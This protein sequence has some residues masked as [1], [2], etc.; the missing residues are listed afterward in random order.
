M[1]A[2]FRCLFTTL[3]F[4]LNAHRLMAEV[5][6]PVFAP[7]GEVS[8]T[9]TSISISCSTP[10]ATIHYTTNGVDPAESDALIQSGSA[11]YVGRNLVLKARAWKDG[12]S[13]A[14]ASQSYSITGQVSAGDY[15][16]LALK[17]DGAKVS[18]WGRNLEGQL[19]TGTTTQQN[20]PIYAIINPSLLPISSIAAKG[21]HSLAITG[22]HN[23]ISWG[24][25]LSGELG[26]GTT[27]NQALAVTVQTGTG[28]G[29]ANLAGIAEVCGGVYSSYALK[30]SG[31]IGTIWSWGS[32]SS[33]KLGDGTTTTRT[34][35]VQVKTGSNS[36]VTNAVALS[37]G[38]NFALALTS[39]NKVLVWG[40]NDN[41][42][43]GDGGSA[44]RYY[45][46][47]IP[48]FEGVVAVAA[49]YSHSLALK[50]NG[51]L[52][53]WGS[54]S[55]GQV[56]D[57]SPTTRRSP[58]QVMM[59][60]T[61]P[62]ENVVEVAAGYLHSLALKADGTVWAWGY[63]SY[64]LLGDGSH[65][66]G[67][68][69]YYPVQVKTGSNS[70]LTNVVAISAGYQLSV[71]L[72]ADGTIYTW[73]AGNYGQL[74]ND[75]V[76]ANSY[77]TPSF[78]SKVINTPPS[79]S[80][81]L[82]AGPYMQGATLT[83]SAV[84]SDT[85]NNLSRVDL[86]QNGSSLGS[87]TSGSNTLTLS[88]V[89]AGQY[90]FTAVATDI[91]GDFGSASVTASVTLPPTTVGISSFDS[92][93]TETSGTSALVTVTRQGGTSGPLSI[94][95]SVAG[96]A[97]S[98]SDYQ[99]LSGTVIIPVGA[100]S[101]CIPITP[102]VDRL[103]E[104]DET[105]TITLNSAFGYSVDANASVATVTIH[106]APPVA[107]PLFATRPGYSLEARPVVVTCA[108]E[109][110]VIH[111]TINGEVPT[112][113][114]TTS[115]I[116][117]QS[118]PNVPPNAIIRLTAC[119]AGYP[120]SDCAAAVYQFGPT[121]KSG[122]YHSLAVDP[123]GKL[124][125]WGDNHA[126]QIG[127][128]SYT[129]QSYPALIP[130]IPKLG[131][132]AAGDSH[133]LCI[134]LDGCVWSWGAGNN[135]QLGNGG[136]ASKL[137]PTKIDAFGP[138][139]YSR[140]V[141]VA[142]GYIF[143][144]ALDSNR[145]VWTWGHNNYGQIGDDTNTQR[146]SPVQV[147]GIDHI[148][149]IAAGYGHAL[150]LRDDG[151][152]WGWGANGSGQL[153]DGT[154]IDRKTPVQVV[155]LNDVVALDAGDDHTVALKADGTVWTW[156]DN[157]YGVL[158]TSLNNIYTPL[159]VQGIDP[160]M[161]VAAGHHHIIALARDG[162]IYTW[163]CNDSGQLGDGTQVSRN[164]RTRVSNLS[165]IV[166]IDAGNYTT[167]AIDRWG[168]IWA[169]GY[170]DGGVLG[171]D[172]S[173][174]V[175]TP[176]RLEELALKTRT[177]SP[178]ISP[179]GGRSLGAQTITIS[180]DTP[181]AV[182]RT[183]TNGAVPTESD[184]I[185]VSGSSITISAPA[186][187]RAKAFLDGIA[188]SATTTVC[189]G[190]G[191][192]VAADGAAHN[193]AL[194]T[195]GTVW[196]WGDNTDGGLGIG[197]ETGVEAVP[198]KLDWS[199]TASVIASSQG[200]AFS[201][202]IDTQGSVWLWGANDRGQLGTGGTDVSISPAQQAGL[203]QVAQIALGISHSLA[204]KQDGTVW[205]WGDNTVGELGTGTMS[206]VPQTSPVQVT[207]TNSVPLS[208][209]V[210]ITSGSNFSVALKGDGTV[211]AWGYDGKGQ[212]GDSYR[213]YTKPNSSRP[214]RVGSAMIGGPLHNVIAIA[215]GVDHTL[216]LKADGTV[217]G[218]GGDVHGQLGDNRV[219]QNRSEPTQA[220]N[221]TNV[222]A[223]YAGNAVSF[224]VKADGTVWAWGDNTKGQYGNGTLVESFVPIQIATLTSPSSIAIGSDHALAAGIAQ[225]V[226]VFSAW[227]TNTGGSLGNGNSDVTAVQSQPQY[228]HLG[229]DSD[230]DG[231]PDWQ[232]IQIGTN[233][234]NWDTDG[235]G[236]P[237]GWEVDNGFNP[238]DP[239]DAQQ[240][241]DGDGLTNLQEYQN[242][243]NPFLVDTD[244]DGIPD[245]WEV[246][247]GLNP[248]DAADA[249]QDYDGDGLTN[250]QEYQN[251][252]N[253]F[254]VDTDGDGI[255]DEWEVRY[256]L[257]PLDPTDAAQDYDGDGYSNY[258]EYIA[259]T[260]PN[261]SESNAGPVLIVDQSNS[262][263]YVTVQSAI[264]A[265]T[266][267]YQ[268]INVSPGTYS[269]NLTISN[270]KLFLAS[271]NGAAVTVIS[272]TADGSSINVANDSQIS[273][274][275]I[276]S[277]STNTS[278]ERGVLVQSGSP[279][280]T[281]CVIR[282]N[283]ASSGAA[284]YSTGANPSF[285]NCTMIGN[286][287]ESG[288]VAT[289]SGTLTIV[290]SILW[291][292]SANTELTGTTLRVSYSDVRGGIAGDGNLDSN[293]AVSQDGHLI[294]PLSVCIGAGQ[295]ASAPQVDMDCEVRDSA[296]DIGADEFVDTDGNQLPDWWERQY[297]GNIGNDAN[298]PAT[299][300]D[301]LSIFQALLQNRNPIDYY[302]GQVV[303]LVEVG[304]GGQLGRAGQ[305]GTTPWTVQLTDAS[306]VP[307]S[308]APVRFHVSAGDGQISLGNDG[309]ASG[310][311]SI[312][313]LTDSSGFA[314]IYPVYPSAQDTDST[315]DATASTSLVQSR[316][317]STSLIASWNL[318]E[319]G[320]VTAEDQ[321][322]LGNVGGIVGSPSWV[323]G[324]D[325]FAALALDGSSQ[326]VQI[327]DKPSLSLGGGPLTVTAWVRLDQNASLASESDCYSV[328]C[329]GSTGVGNIEFS[330]RGG[331]FNGLCAKLSDGSDSFD[332]KAST[333]QSGKLKDNCW[334]HV[335]FV[336]HGSGDGSIFLDGLLVGSGT[337]SNCNIDS[338]QP[339]WIGRNGAG[340]HLMGS[341]ARVSVYARDLS[342]GEVAQ[343]RNADYD[344]DG[345]PDWWE[346]LQGLNPQDPTD[347]ALDPDG[348]GLSNIEEFQLGTN[349][350]IDSNSG[351][352]TSITK[353]SGDNQNG[354]PNSLLARPMV[355][356]VSD[357]NGNPLVNAPVIFSVEQ[358]GGQLTSGTFSPLHADRIPLLTDTTGRVAI[359]YREGTVFGTNSTVNATVA[360]N[361][362]QFTASSSPLVGL[363]K[364][365]ER[366]G[367]TV[368][369]LSNTEPQV[370]LTG[371]VTWTTGFDGKGAISL[372]GTSG[373]VA[374]TSNAAL[375]T[376][377]GAY[378]IATW[379]RLPSDLDLGDE[380]LR[381]PL[382][383]VGD[384]DAD[385]LWIGIRGGGHGLAAILNAPAGNTEIDG[386]VDQSSLCDGGW[387]HIALVFDGAN[388][389]IFFDGETI[390]SQDCDGLPLTA[391]PH[392]W[393]AK[394]AAGLF[395]GGSID[396]TEVRRDSLSGDDIRARYNVD[397]N[398]DGIPDRW[399]W[400]YFGTLD[401]DP[402]ADL[403]GDGISNFD[404]FQNGTDPTDPA[405]LSSLGDFTNINAVRS[406][407]LMAA[408]MTMSAS[409][410]S[411][412]TPSIPTTPGSM[413]GSFAVSPSG[414]ATYSVPISVPKGASGMEPKLFLNYSSQS[415]NGS[416][417]LGW[418][419]GGLSVI[420]RGP[421]NLA[422][423]GRID[424]VNFDADDQ[425]FLD[426]E[427]LIPIH[428]KGGADGT[429]YRTQND[430]FYK[431]ISHG[432]Y[433][434]R[435]PVWWEVKTKSGLT[436]RIGD[437]DCARIDNIAYSAVISWAVDEIIDRNNNYL[438]VWYD[439]EFKASVK[440]AANYEPRF[441]WYTGN[442]EVKPTNQVEF[443][444]DTARPD[445]SYGFVVGNPVKTEKRLTSIR[446]Y[447]RGNLNGVS[448]DFNNADT[449]TSKYAGT[450][451]REYRL[452]YESTSGYDSTRQ[453]QR[454]H[455]QSIQ[456]IA[457]DEQGY[458]A[459]AFPPTVFTWKKPQ[460][461]GWLAAPNWKVN[462][463][464]AK[465][466]CPDRGVVFIDVNGDGLVDVIWNRKKSDGTFDKGAYINTGTGWA[467]DSRF[468]PPI[469]LA[470]DD[471]S[472]TGARI[473]D[474][475]GDG[476][477]DIVGPTKCYI[478]VPNSGWVRS[479][480][481]ALPPEAALVD[482]D[483]GMRVVDLNGDGRA[484]LLYGHKT[485]SGDVKKAWIATGTGWNPAPEW[486][487]PA[488]FSNK[489]NEV[490]RH[491]S[492]LDVNGDGLPD[493]IYRDGDQVGCFM[494]K[495]AGNGTVPSS[496]W[497]SDE[498]YKPLTQITDDGR[499]RG[500]RLVDMNGDGLPDF[501][502]RF[503]GSDSDDPDQMGGWF[504][505]GV[506]IKTADGGAWRYDSSLIPP[507]V[508]AKRANGTFRDGE[509]GCRFVDLNGDGLM[510]LVRRHDV[511][512]IYLGYIDQK[513]NFSWK[514]SSAWN[515]PYSTLIDDQVDAG[516]RF[517]DLNGDG[518]PDF[519]YNR[520][521]RD[522]TTDSGAYINKSTPEVIEK[523]TNGLGSWVSF[524]YKPLSDG[525]VYAKG[526]SPK[527]PS[528]NVTPTTQVV[529][530]CSIDNGQGGA[531]ATTYNYS[532]LQQ[533]QLGRGSLGFGQ[534]SQTTVMGNDWT[535]IIDSYCHDFPF[536]GLLRS[537]KKYAGL[538]LVAS[539][540]NTWV[541][542]A[543]PYFESGAKI[544]NLCFV[545]NK[546]SIIKEF[547]AEIVGSNMISS[548]TT[549]NAYDQYG[550]LTDSTIDSGAG[551]KKVLHN[552]YAAPSVADLASWTL[553]RLKDA[554]SQS[555]APGVNATTAPRKASSFT[556]KAN[557][558]LDG[559][560][561]EPGNAN[562][563]STTY[564]ADR[565]GNIIRTD[566]VGAANLSDDLVTLVTGTRSSFSQYD[567]TGRF[568]LSATNA[569]GQASFTDPDYL[570][571]L[572][573]SVTDINGLTTSF[574]YDRFGRPISK[575]D[576][577]GVVAS[578]EFS[579]DSGSD[580]YWPVGAVYSVKQ[581]TT[582]P[583]TGIATAA[584]GTIA[585]VSVSYYDRLN[586]VLRIRSEIF[587]KTQPGVVL[588]DTKYDAYGRTSMTSLPYV[589]GSTQLWIKY[590]YDAL[591][592]VVRVTN[593]DDSYAFWGYASIRGGGSRVIA[594]DPLG[595]S[596]TTETNR[597]GQ[598]TK[599][600]DCQNGVI[601]YAYDAYGNPKST[602]SPGNVVTSFTYDAF[603][604]KLAMT[605]ADMGKW[606]Y[607]YNGFGE[608]IQQ[609]NVAAL[610]KGQPRGQITPALSTYFWYDLSGRT[611][612]K[613]AQ[614]TNWGF[615]T[616]TYVYDNSTNGPA[617]TRGK[618]LSV[619]KS[620]S[621][622]RE[623]YGY[624]DK[625]R[626]TSIA[627]T[628]NTLASGTYTIGKTYDEIGREKTTTYPNGFAT[629]NQYD[630]KGWLCSVVNA[631]TPSLAY[632]T[633]DSM[634]AGGRVTGESFGNGANTRHDYDPKTG[635]TTDIVTTSGTGAIQYNHYAFNSL[636]NLMSRQDR[637]QG[638]QLETFGYDSLNR[639]ISAVS[640]T[641]STGV[642]YDASGGILSKDGVGTYVYNTASH[643][644][645]SIKSGTTVLSSYTY[646][647]RGNMLTGAGRTYTWNSEDK[648]VTI[649]DT[650]GV[651]ASFTYG[652]GGEI[653]TE[654]L[655]GPNT[656][657][658][659]THIGGIYEVVADR[660]DGIGV[661]V[662]KFQRCYIGG[663]AVVIKK[664]ADNSTTTRYFHKDHLG[665]VEAVTDE[666]G[667]VVERF[668]YDAWGART[669]T[670][671]TPDAAS[672]PTTEQGFTGHQELDDLGLI[673]MIGRVYDPVI[674]RFVSAD[675][676]VQAPGNSQ[677]YNRYSYCINNPL[678]LTDPTGYSWLSS[679]WNA[680][681]HA[682][683]K[684]GAWVGG[685]CTSAGKWIS[686]NWRTIVVVVATVV[687]TVATAGTLTTALGPLWGVVASGALAGAVNG[688]L[689]TA[690][691]GGSASQI[692]HNALRGAI[693]GGVTAGLTYGIG[694]AA[695]SLFGVEEAEGLEGCLAK[696]P[697]EGAVGGGLSAA[698]GG[699]FKSGFIGG[700]VGC[701]SGGVLDGSTNVALNTVIA[702]AAGGTVSVLCGGSFAN[703]AV[704]AAFAYVFNAVAHRA[705]AMWEYPESRVTAYGF[706]KDNAYADHPDGGDA[707]SYASDPSRND[708]DIAHAVLGDG[709]F[710]YPS[711][712]AV[713]P[714]SGIR[715]GSRV[716]VESRGWFVVED[717][718][719]EDMDIN[720]FDM[721]TGR[722]DIALRSS[723]SGR[724]NV[725]V[726]PKGL[727]VPD[728]WRARGAGDSWGFAP[729]GNTRSAYAN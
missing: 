281:N 112:E 455:L 470:A 602:K 385:N 273:G 666:L 176:A 661:A 590:E 187:V 183:S 366:T 305:T 261:D 111:Y 441:I 229:T 35:A 266:Q 675:P 647:A 209:I 582:A 351:V 539:T 117:G 158:G 571:G 224:A 250:L 5:A 375:A 484:D 649:S 490:S 123:D 73:G 427:R 606:T 120:A 147:A 103:V 225:G 289:A 518:F 179:V 347:A 615:L 57:G 346:T 143:S 688:G 219:W 204:L 32:N 244:G 294:D 644:L 519:I 447:T 574:T 163:G 127:N 480:T 438:W 718:C 515:L 311:N 202:A 510:D 298:A 495:G 230:G 712:L 295:P 79:V 1:R 198:Q 652:P 457:K 148:V 28:S 380:S 486:A 726:F 153:G 468:A 206:N 681:T 210:A 149:A 8:Y 96:S 170:S 592:R 19:A 612:T 199:S 424:G 463:P 632:W 173:S 357:T 140:A 569:Y 728:N 536:T 207:A 367:C 461:L 715:M 440:D 11:V 296:P 663:A 494:N 639:L 196:A 497:Q 122:A 725:Y 620:D 9:A 599:V 10:G 355:V 85:D 345:I 597:V 307:I 172:S 585:P 52:W 701:V 542:E 293:P 113:S 39:S 190:V 201:G 222:I 343:A 336:R 288:A 729:H 319:G 504:N 511:S 686:K 235:D 498:N 531:I 369:D 472:D 81:T 449:Y 706:G 236:M 118:I 402:F 621:T 248:L 80:L 354:V 398:S 487:P 584:D 399:E 326:F 339:F 29:A 651:T 554:N 322:G 360:Q 388:I 272:G 481:F 601:T 152:V 720:T 24:R 559:E 359:C 684:A 533:D 300:G 301:G 566:M 394:D 488:T 563:T 38:Y 687:V 64:G 716:Y 318:D 51:L 216:A 334:H 452:S 131:S 445:Y 335:A 63:D 208:G 330:M 126:G 640:G 396:D 501:I 233:P 556:Y 451:A 643:S 641:A 421:T 429:E 263:G 253:P 560:V 306:G 691:Y 27:A 267:D 344:Q 286:S 538:T 162:T 157:N 411:T 496:A 593:P 238:L 618:L 446:C 391:A 670:V 430:K 352:T 43:L 91:T 577:Y 283:K 479:A 358:G 658:V 414:A 184:Q 678:S 287:S 353:I 439:R 136:V 363:F 528:S 331:E 106:D 431:I 583:E 419:L 68:S 220:R 128:N 94:S 54:N 646:D 45:A 384:G 476:I 406:D 142:A 503:P 161:A 613:S 246:R 420:T 13:S 189:Y 711:S 269:E 169:T 98:G 485:S 223:I 700:A 672:V 579:S 21:M 41:G 611:V 242:G 265:V 545:Y 450:M 174:D 20:S 558:T 383:T 240:D 110:A 56:G 350:Y 362:V 86:F 212:L 237:D 150:A 589:S 523:V 381:Y 92:A 636:G 664:V 348:D 662:P 693:V 84:A 702:A 167:F 422:D 473:A 540:E 361:V 316:I 616:T 175:F 508:L 469:P 74:G 564:Q 25:N 576:A 549:T 522:G 471:Q 2:I 628:L 254:L 72:T 604:R 155:G 570:L 529:A 428:G 257:N 435:G 537:T 119:L 665:S 713:H 180:C 600:T 460:S 442:A 108:T 403:D 18:A 186:V 465:D 304:G 356:L 49:G 329:K 34:T 500:R 211:W 100:A 610:G 534:I 717:R 82:S 139:S 546:T 227:G 145:N 178:N 221:L 459:V 386:W 555:F 390:A 477:P 285:V 551:Y 364:Y 256:G 532:D 674:G 714:D 432:S 405:N 105:V 567:S 302:D 401:V 397:S 165:E 659:T 605:D 588:K 372:D 323:T 137:V 166:S 205:A 370:D 506:S 423:D 507:M 483:N 192:Q 154:T 290:N 30:L 395:F 270:H 337:A 642:T 4:T 67:Y 502:Y 630:G 95:Y 552:N 410:A 31:T 195:D 550:N 520:L 262:D 573:K 676:T 327:D 312:A 493:I 243:T 232:E 325:S 627:Y 408:P 159:Q 544:N 146:N 90:T 83:L 6:T 151:T 16:V 14:V 249:A 258:L 707:V 654:N 75:T 275:T 703:G 368:A 69:T 626:M 524:Q 378:T 44:S 324:C 491:E 62:M 141:A 638:G 260:D 535:T 191:P 349:P 132:V 417:G 133:S 474:V 724:L 512:N 277:G 696:A 509:Y 297:Y 215:S 59:S 239:S 284:I 607:R 489:D 541:S 276:T 392:L 561:V 314:K 116:S 697:F 622:Y 53:A 548:V 603:G 58:V 478:A 722:S 3:L 228:A 160:V 677:S 308:N 492:I 218:W 704:S 26:N 373:Y 710:D 282:N 61:Q 376:G 382:V 102:I 268:L 685:I 387:H 673:H 299:R 624:G 255:P 200:G 37:A 631:L 669:K 315:L 377:T 89:L 181:G 425:Y 389:Q 65:G 17:S 568:I 719:A 516:S 467:E 252:T 572:P 633:L 114:S 553:G 280:F 614:Q 47:E 565:F 197:S 575:K 274:F 371:G 527:Y 683:G 404:E 78:C 320:G 107:K 723:L 657:Q 525:S 129:D 241:Y 655:F 156:G 645:K 453:T 264:D 328:I 101:A 682:V 586:R 271:S 680:I 513:F 660:P 23:V 443:V 625:G 454:S 138:P 185:V 313:V 623:D 708:G 705:A 699:S 231:V 76:A 99:P 134:D 193:Y 340:A 130:G 77:A 581:T 247:Y 342:A 578:T 168:S 595:Q 456:E 594:E 637:L 365:E 93:V 245:E 557:G 194:Q 379:V 514:S 303:N 171:N 690:L 679:A 125:A 400:K 526:A 333:D 115:V 213:Y 164:A 698:Q 217:W 448:S 608:L 692:F 203:A 374:V 416:I 87:F 310:V 667:Q 505:S 436:M 668:A 458:D 596:T 124:W 412:A 653:V 434:A 530:S 15:H 88:N 338:D 278:G 104:G 466:G 40:G 464:I 317:R 721:W 727:A 341:I 426:G 7:P 694:S 562:S 121:I 587:G 251:G 332:V 629:L 22:S 444:Y 656:Q 66:Y 482:G 437:W 48:N 521:K 321:S 188:P 617:N 598:V 407:A 709:S 609:T 650:K 415:G 214:V 109:G 234:V 619:S 309:S 689:S 671:G 462:V 182:I 279:K 291:N 259:Q 55:S 36:Y 409:L 580:P 12:E 413:A 97:T 543:Y 393:L 135:G 648:P 634:D 46:Y 60:G 70:F 71:A 433:G 50:S 292:P 177:A 42:E 695:E 418:S 591:G 517:V 33:G 475:N 226:D 499:D 547:G 144:I 635:F